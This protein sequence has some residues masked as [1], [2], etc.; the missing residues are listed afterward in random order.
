MFMANPAQLSMGNAYGP[1]LPTVVVVGKY[2]GIQTLQKGRPG[3]PED[4]SQPN[5]GL[6]LVD[7]QPTHL[8]WKQSKLDWLL[9]E[10]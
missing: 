4:Q 6:V 7:G 2:M 8:P 10:G 5:L 3:E 9:I 1:Y